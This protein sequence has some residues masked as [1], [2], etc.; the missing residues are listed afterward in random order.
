MEITKKQIRQAAW[1]LL[2]YASATVVAVA[3]SYIVYQ[4][5]INP[6]QFR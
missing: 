4:I 5:V 6:T 3:T 2:V 1:A